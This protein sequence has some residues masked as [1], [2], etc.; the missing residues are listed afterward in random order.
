[1]IF[2]L[3]F[4]RSKH[5]RGGSTATARIYSARFQFQ[6]ATTTGRCRCRGGTGHGP[7]LRTVHHDLGFFLCHPLFA[8]KNWTYLLLSA[9][10]NKLILVFFSQKQTSPKL[11]RRHHYYPVLSRVYK[12][13]HTTTINYTSISNHAPARTN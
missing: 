5:R 12:L 13:T 8:K 1:M 10:G 2:L 7:P 6:L 9:A 11:F 4:Y 3:L